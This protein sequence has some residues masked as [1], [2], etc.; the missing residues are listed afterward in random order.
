[1]VQAVSHAAIQ[2]RCVISGQWTINTRLQFAFLTYY[3][4]TSSQ[5]EP[6]RRSDEEHMKRHREI[7]EKI[8][9]LKQLKAD[10]APASPL[11]PKA[12]NI[13]SRQGEESPLTKKERKAAKKAKKVSEMAKVVSLEEVLAFEKT[14]SKHRHLQALEIERKRSNSQ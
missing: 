7:A 8:H 5:C 2:E 14:I 10:G 9:E 1:M 4:G 11:T 6:C 13:L 3:T 12:I